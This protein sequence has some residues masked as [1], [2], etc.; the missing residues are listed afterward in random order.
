MYVILLR[1]GAGTLQIGALMALA[2]A[3][4]LG[5]ELILIK[6]LAGREPPFQILLTNNLL[7]VGVSTLAVLPFWVMPSVAQGIGLALL[8]FLMAGAQT[9][10][11]N[12]MARA[13]ASFVTPFSYLTL[14]F[15]AVYDLL[16]FAVWPDRVSWLGAAVILAGAALLAWREGLARR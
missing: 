10:F 1:P 7:G 8:G 15:A 3:L 11:V 4:V 6:K 9:C 12:A 5:F 14:V 13:D 2:A 16:F